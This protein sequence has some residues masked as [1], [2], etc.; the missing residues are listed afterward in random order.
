M[1]R[2]SLL[3]NQLLIQQNPSPNRIARLMGEC[4]PGGREM[5]VIAAKKQK[6]DPR[7]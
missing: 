1:L 7:A 4:G 3:A 2:N 5:A 6:K